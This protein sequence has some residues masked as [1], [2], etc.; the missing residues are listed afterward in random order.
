MYV[1]MY[2]CMD[3]RRSIV[4]SVA[5]WAVSTGTHVTEVR[6]ATRVKPYG[7]TGS[8]ACGLLGCGQFRSR[9][10]GGGPVPQLRALGRRY[11]VVHI[12]TNNEELQQ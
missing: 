9:L 3:F 1:G 12:T 2:V 7:R 8:S 10:T 11:R 6:Q 5:V 4:I